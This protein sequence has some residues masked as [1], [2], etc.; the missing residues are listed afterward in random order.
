MAT[1]WFLSATASLQCVAGD[2]TGGS[3]ESPIEDEGTE[4]IAVGP[5]AGALNEGAYAL[6][7]GA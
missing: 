2:D 7:A 5:D 3:V 1:P 6:G 4:L